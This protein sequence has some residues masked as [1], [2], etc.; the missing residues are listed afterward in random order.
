MKFTLPVPKAEQ[1]LDLGRA[2]AYEAAR[3]GEIPTITMGRRR[4][5]PIRALEQILRLE[6]GTLGEREFEPG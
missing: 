4:L 6:P 3:K 2:A 5:V 1:I